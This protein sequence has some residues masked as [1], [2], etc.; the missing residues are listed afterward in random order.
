VA[1][2]ASPAG[3]FL[4]RFGDPARY[5]QGDPPRILENWDNATTGH[6]QMGGSH[7]ATWIRPGLNGAG[8]LM[9]FNNG[10]YLFQATPQSSILEIDPSLDA[11]GRDTGAYVNPPAAGYRME[12]Y[13]KDTHNRPR[14]I[15]NQV[16]WTYRSVNS[17]N[18]FSHIGSS[19]QRLPNGNTFICADTEGHFF[20]VTS[21]GELVWEYI[22][23]IT[24][25]GAVKTLSD[26][27]P[28][29]NS[30]FRAFRYGPDH[31]AF[32]GH[33][34]TPQGT[35]TERAAKGLDGRPGRGGGAR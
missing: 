11:N 34:L 32:A 24:R 25:A 6:R 28:M 14:Q 30:V 22:N 29:T 12:Q 31:P 1:K 15:S 3:D 8:H 4:Y 2:A 21:Q 16:V 23:P 35:I 17:H 33:D 7:H 27:L 20:E 13:D 26:V 5:A 19:G 9:V 18:F 10:Q